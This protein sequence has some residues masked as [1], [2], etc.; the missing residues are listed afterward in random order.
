MRTIRLLAA[1]AVCL[2]PTAVPAADPIPVVATVPNLGAIAEAVGGDRIK[3]T[4]IASGVQDAHFIDP[5][6]SFILKV[7]AARLLLV[8]GL[9][10]EIGWI[11]PLTEGARN[12]RVLR[13]GEGYI[14]CS[15]GIEVVEIPTGAISRAMGDVHPYGNPHYL[16][17][18]VNAVFVARRLADLFAAE[19]PADAE[20][21][22]ARLESFTRKLSVALFGAELVDLVGGDRLARLARTGELEGYLSATVVDGAPLTA[23]LGGWTGRMRRWAGTNIVTYH[24]DWSYF[25]HR[26]G[27]HVVDYVEPKPGIPP[28]AKHLVEL[29]ERL[30]RG[31]VRLIVTRPFLEKRSTTRLR[32]STGVPVVTLPIEVGGAEGTGDYIALFD[33]VIATLDA[34]LGARPPGGAPRP[35]PPG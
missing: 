31:D 29:T 19:S 9:D 10:L 33:H 12:A 8:N 25:A 3:V 35:A 32:E 22:R 23:K 5:K 28:S 27:L 16:T 1:A 7:R 21:F 14:D 15:A 4:T 13:G 17:D 6:P 24:R 18:P 20:S 30:S 26:F 2:V 34:A 11:P